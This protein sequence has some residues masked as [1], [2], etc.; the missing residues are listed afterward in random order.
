LPKTL[1]EIGELLELLVLLGHESDARTLQRVVGECVE[2]YAAAHVDA[3][4]SLKEL[5]AIAKAQGEPLEPFEPKDANA[6]ATEWKWS[7]LRAS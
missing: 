4:K 3:E 2:T 6:A 7:L 5:K 1:E